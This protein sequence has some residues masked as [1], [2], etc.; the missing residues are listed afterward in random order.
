MSVDRSSVWMRPVRPCRTGLQNWDR[1]P[2]LP[3]RRCA[4][5]RRPWT[6]SSRTS[7]QLFENDDVRDN[8]LRMTANLRQAQSR[9]EQPQE[10]APGGQG[11]PAAAPAAR[12]RTRRRRRSPSPSAKGRSCSAQ[13]RRRS[14]RRLV[15]ALAGRRR[16]G[17][18]RLRRRRAPP[19]RWSSPAS[20][21]SKGDQDGR[22]IGTQRP[23][24]SRARQATVR[25]DQP[26]RPPRDGAGEGRAVRQGQGG[27]HRRRP[28]RRRGRVRAVRAGRAHRHGRSPC[29]APRWT[30]GW[31]R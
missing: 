26:A 19:A 2:A 6:D 31:P 13:R 18:P 23:V 11:P 25:A 3:E 15:L 1:C 5:C 30:R 21:R 20:D 9:A 28:V 29:S 16:R 24:G 22:A 14:R 17:L 4:D 7:T 27:R 8:F 10:Q 12:E